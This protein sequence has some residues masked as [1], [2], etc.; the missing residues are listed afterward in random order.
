MHHMPKPVLSAIFLYFLLFT[1]AVV[2]PV[3][4]QTTPPSDK[5]TAADSS[6]QPAIIEELNT[7]ARFENNGNSVQMVRQRVKVQNEAGIRLYGIITFNFIAGQE[8]SIDTVEVHKK[9]GSTVKAGP[10]NIQEVTPEISRAAPMYSDVRQKQ[11]TV[12]GLSVGDEVVFQYT[13]KD[14]A[15]VPNQ[16]W[17]QYSFSK[18]A[19]VLSESVQLDIPGG[20]KVHVSFQPGYKPEVKTS[21]E[22]T[23]YQ[24]HTANEKVQEKPRNVLLKENMTGT[25]PASSIQLSTFENWDQV[26]SWYYGLQHERAAPWN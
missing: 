17:F 19:I 25:A 20:R 23:I 22:R 10:A 2:T 18:T 15:L 24:W 21:G 9:D 11:V 12:P 3:I 26:G 4:S 13:A 7:S 5:K 1:C 16:F 14:S 6:D 8:F